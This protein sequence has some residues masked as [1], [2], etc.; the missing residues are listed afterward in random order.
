MVGCYS[1]QVRIKQQHRRLENELLAAEKCW[2][3]HRCRGWRSILKRTRLER[4]DVRTVPTTCCRALP[5]SRWRRAGCVCS[6]RADGGGAHA[7]QGV[8]LGLR[9]ADAGAGRRNPVL[10]IQPAPVVEV[11]T[12]IVCEFMLADQYLGDQ[13]CRIYFGVYDEAGPPPWIL[14]V[15]KGIQ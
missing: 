12:D 9:R 7:H 11:E 5:S 1:S 6:P 15:E 3:A 2:P 4:P 13:L 8:F 14:Q 10:D